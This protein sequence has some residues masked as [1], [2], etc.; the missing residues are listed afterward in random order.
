MQNSVQV[1]YLL[2]YSWVKADVSGIEKKMLGLY[3]DCM[4]KAD[5]AT[6]TANHSRVKSLNCNYT[7]NMFNQEKQ[8]LLY[9]LA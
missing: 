5:R 2:A 7:T 6:D 9:F 3:K 1:H 4:L 8:V